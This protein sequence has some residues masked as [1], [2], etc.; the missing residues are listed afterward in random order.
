MK[1]YLNLTKYTRS[2]KSKQSRLKRLGEE[3]RI[4]EEGVQ[5]LDLNLASLN[6]VL[7]P[8]VPDAHVLRP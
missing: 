7:H 5:V 4:M 3:V 6:Q 2:K 1:R 8:E